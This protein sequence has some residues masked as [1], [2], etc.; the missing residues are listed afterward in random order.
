MNA[1][2]EVRIRHMLWKSISLVKVEARIITHLFLPIMI[3][4]PLLLNNNHL[5]IHHR[6]HLP[7]KP[8][9]LQ[10]LNIIWIMF[11]AEANGYACFQLLPLAVCC[12][13]PSYI[14]IYKPKHT[15]PLYH[16]PYLPEKLQSS[17]S[18]CIFI[19]MWFYSLL[20]ASLYPS[21]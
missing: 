17:C 20:H 12:R 15:Y 14:S 6:I 19:Y 21:L 4:L 3:L 13:N 1:L 7:M 11:T 9:L 10:L 2:E 5:H 8:M 18:H 16:L